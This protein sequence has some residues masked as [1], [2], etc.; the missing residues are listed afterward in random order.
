MVT[1]RRQPL[2][3]R[4]LLSADDV[5]N[6]EFNNLEQADEFYVKYARCVGFGV[7]KVI[8]AHDDDGNKDP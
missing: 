8:V 5:M 2:K 3:S 4:V 1:T 6:M 7:R